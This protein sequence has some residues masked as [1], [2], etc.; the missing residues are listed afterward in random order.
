MYGKKIGAMAWMDLS[1]PD[2][3]QIKNF[4]KKY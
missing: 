4:I 3:E 1:V 2:A